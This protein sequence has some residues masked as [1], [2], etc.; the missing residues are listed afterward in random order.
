MR[1][2]QFKL[3]C[4]S[5]EDSTCVTTRIVVHCYHLFFCCCCWLLLLIQQFCVVFSFENSDLPQIQGGKGYHKMSGMMFIEKHYPFK[6]FFGHSLIN[7]Q[8]QCKTYLCQ[9]RSKKQYPVFF[10]I[11]KSKFGSNSRWISELQNGL[12][13]IYRKALPTK[14][15]FW[16]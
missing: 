2:S 5:A 14:W 8:Q 6:L 7:V 16:H 10:T 9:W 15:F 11:K 3:G 1:S 4:F 12:N 13:D